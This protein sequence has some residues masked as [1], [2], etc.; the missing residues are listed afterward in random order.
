MSEW[1]TSHFATTI[2]AHARGDLAAGMEA[3]EV[4]L[5]CTGLPPEIEE[6]TRRNQTW[7]LQP[8]A[9]T[10]NSAVFREPPYVTSQRVIL[11]GIPEGWSQFNPSIASD[12]DGNLRMIVRSSNYTV[13]GEMRY[14]I[15]DGGGVIRTTNYVMDLLSPEILGE[16]ERIEDDRPDDPPFP[17]AGYEDARLF[18]HNGWMFSATVRDRGSRGICQ[19]VVGALNGTDIVHEWVLSD[20]RRHEKNWMPVEHTNH[21]IAECGPRTISTCAPLGGGWW[22]Q[23]PHIARSFRG[24]SQL[25]WDGN[26][27]YLAMIHEAVD[28]PG[29]IPARVYQHR[30]VEFDFSGYEI[31][32]ISLPFSFHGRGLEFAAG[33]VLVGDDLIISYGVGD[34][35]AWLLRLPL[36]RALGMLKEP[37][38]EEG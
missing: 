5:S 29:S 33:M 17:V 4:L 22:R 9:A 18:W 21:F 13:D 23:A 7:H 12:P 31:Q 15:H 1:W 36:E 10:G 19:M 11:P 3:C 14:T 30:F 6:A 32:R 34:A 35:S 26:E 28:L 2:E 25:I 20:Q 8:L 16:P 27:T 37:L 24:G 38:P